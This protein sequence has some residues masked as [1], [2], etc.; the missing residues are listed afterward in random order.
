M[1]VIPLNTCR[2]LRYSSKVIS[3]SMKAFLKLCD[4]VDLLACGWCGGPCYWSPVLLAFLPSQDTVSQSSMAMQPTL[5][6]VACGLNHLKA[7]CN[8]PVPLLPAQCTPEPHADIGGVMRRKPLRDLEG[9]YPGSPL[10]PSEATG[11]TTAP[12]SLS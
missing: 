1:W 4:C 12:P 2:I 8:S 9:S 5:N 6:F 10:D 3:S 11:V 7:M